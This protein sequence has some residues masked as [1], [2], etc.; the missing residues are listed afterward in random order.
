MKKTHIIII[1]CLTIFLTEGS[2]ALPETP[3]LASTVEEPASADNIE[4]GIYTNPFIPKLPEKKV[5]IIPEIVEPIIEAPPI[6]VETPVQPVEIVETSKLIVEAPELSISGLIWNSEFPQAIVNN[7]II[8]LGDTIEGATIV[9]IHQDGID[10]T[11]EGDQ[12][13]ISKNVKEELSDDEKNSFD[14]N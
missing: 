9:G 7:Q 11:Y 10:I 3:E 14:N 2:L 8:Q 5:E 6:E 12:F 13:T 1:F 4:E